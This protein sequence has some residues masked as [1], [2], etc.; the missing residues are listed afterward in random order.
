[1]NLEDAIAHAIEVSEGCA[2]DGICGYQ[3]DKLVD[4][5]KELQRYKALEKEG[6]LIELSCT[7]GD[8][9]Y[10]VE[11]LGTIKDNC[12]TD[13]YSCVECC[14]YSE[15]E[16][17]RHL[18]RIAEWKMTSV[19]V[20]VNAME[21]LWKTAFFSYETAKQFICEKG[22]LLCEKPSMKK[23]SWHI[24]K[25]DGDVVVEIV[26]IDSDYADYET[27]KNYEE[28]LYSD[29][30]LKESEFTVAHFEEESE[31]SENGGLIWTPE[32]K[33]YEEIFQKTS[34]AK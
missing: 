21:S 6:R 9:L 14:P 1:M 10:R 22:G 30:T 25:T 15:E 24:Q 5:L 28:E 23:G 12:K 27:L 20:I 34:F 2:A 3:H 17:E 8:I 26:D 18:F 4:W 11:D 33:F 7:V 16:M 19:A 32:K 29:P 31:Q 13:C